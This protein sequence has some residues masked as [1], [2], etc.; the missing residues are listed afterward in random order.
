MEEVHHLHEDIVLHSLHK[1]TF[2]YGAKDNW[3]PQ[4]YCREMMCRFPMADVRLCQSD[5]PH[6]FV[7]Q[8]DSAQKLAEMV[9]VWAEVHIRSTD[10]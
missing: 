9:S 3:C 1:L 6:A 2:Y 10:R 4:E 8:S 5:I 7:L